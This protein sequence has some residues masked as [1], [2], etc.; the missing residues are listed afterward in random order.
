MGP[1]WVPIKKYIPRTYGFWK[2]TTEI[3]RT[4]SDKAILIESYALE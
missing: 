1:M 3:V 2:S 4:K